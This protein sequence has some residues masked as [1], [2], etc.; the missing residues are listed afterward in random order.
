VLIKNVLPHADDLHDGRR[1][2]PYDT[3][4]ISAKDFQL[5]H[6]QSRLRDGAIVVVESQEKTQSGGV[7]LPDVDRVTEI[8]AAIES[9]PEAERTELKARFRERENEREKPRKGVLDATEPN[10]KE[11]A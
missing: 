7:A 3:S 5:R 2:L 8:I 4:A 9:A 11:N 1:I 6:Y 10:P